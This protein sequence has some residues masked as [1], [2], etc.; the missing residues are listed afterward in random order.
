VVLTQ[1]STPLKVDLVVTFL[2]ATR[3]EKGLT[4]RGLARLAGMSGAGIR[5]IESGN[6]SPTLDSLFRIAEAM[7][8]CMH[9]VIKLSVKKV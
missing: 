1:D 3:Q 5:M 8:V 9:D 2:K 7:E 6:R 4:V